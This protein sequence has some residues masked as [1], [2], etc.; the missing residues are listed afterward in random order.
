MKYINQKKINLGN[1]ELHLAAGCKNTN[2]CS[3]YN[4]DAGAAVT[5]GTQ[6]TAVGNL[7]AWVTG[8]LQ[9]QTRTIVPDSARFPQQPPG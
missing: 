4:R 5:T 9:R 6:N 1:F 2:N 3:A 8:G 7:A